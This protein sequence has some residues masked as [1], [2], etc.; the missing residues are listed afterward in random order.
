MGTGSPTLVD[1]RRRVAD[2]YA[3][4]RSLGDPAA[5]HEVW[6]AGRD[7]LLRHHPE[8]PVP[9]PE[10]AAFTGVPVAPYD[11]AYRFEVAL[12]EAAQGL[13]DGM[14]GQPAHLADERAQAVEVLVERLDRMSAGGRHVA[15]SDQP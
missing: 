4:V 1:W 8:S 3:E 5:A 2:L 11:P 7:E 15:C 14:L 10:R 9:Q 6:R 12:D 13:A